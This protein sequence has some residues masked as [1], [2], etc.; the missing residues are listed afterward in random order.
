M[1]PYVGSGL[2]DLMG[3]IKPERIS[4]VLLS[5]HVFA[6]TSEFEGLPLSMLEAL[7]AGL[8]PVVTNVASGIGEICVHNKNALISP[9]GEPEALAEN[10]LKLAKTPSLFNALS[11]ASRET[12][13]NEKLRAV[14]MAEQYAVVLD[15]MFERICDA[16][17][18]RTDSLIYCP[19]IERLLNVA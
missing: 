6:L 19:Q 7:S 14:D 17:C 10:L 9:I 16:G 5:S 1:D 12:F 2:V 15:K 18:E 4:E 11:V 8:V 13:I 3:R